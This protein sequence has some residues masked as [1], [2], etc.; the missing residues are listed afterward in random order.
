MQ[1]RTATNEPVVL[2]ASFGYMPSSQSHA[3]KQVRCI[4]LSQFHDVSDVTFRKVR[5]VI[6][7]FRR[8]VLDANALGRL[9][10]LVR[11]KR[12]SI[13]NT[14]G[15]KK[16]E[17]IPRLHAPVPAVLYGEER[18]WNASGEGIAASDDSGD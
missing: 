3:I 12:W 11:K 2:E 13:P 14:C 9:G 10:D 1:G 18:S 16:A 5:D 4:G 8:P 6:A 7:T 17:K 15:S